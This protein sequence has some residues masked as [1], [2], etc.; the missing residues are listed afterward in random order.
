MKQR[1]LIIEKALGKI[2]K[3]L[4]LSS[5][6]ERELLDEIRAHLEDVADAAC[7]KGQDEEIAIFKAAESLDL[8]GLGVELQKVHAPWESADAIIACALPVLLALVMRWLVFAPDGS[9]GDWRLTAETARLL[10]LRPAFWMVAIAALLVPLLHFR[11]WHYALVGWGIF[12][13]LTL[14]FVLFPVASRF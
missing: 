9:A 1:S 6:K 4:D 11:R 7:V 8:E 10:L 12:W 13:A 3:Q 14:V 2:R 5:E